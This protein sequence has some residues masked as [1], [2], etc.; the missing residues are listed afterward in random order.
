M[1]IA[2]EQTPAQ[3]AKELDR[4]LKSGIILLDRQS[5]SYKFLNPRVRE[6]A[7]SMLDEVD[8][9]YLHLKIGRYLL[10]QTNPDRI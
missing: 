7:Y 5:N 8:R 1:A 10:Q 2:V 9:V 6:T 4:A 3:T